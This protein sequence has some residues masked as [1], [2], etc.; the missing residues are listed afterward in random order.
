MNFDAAKHD[1]KGVI[2]VKFLSHFVHRKWPFVNYVVILDCIK[3][4]KTEL[5]IYNKNNLKHG[6]L[7]NAKH[8][9]KQNGMNGFGQ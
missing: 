9:I 4:N 6:A 1:A 7:F 3:L 8:Q 2:T 5:Q